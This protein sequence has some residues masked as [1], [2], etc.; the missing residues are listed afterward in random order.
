MNRNQHLLNWLTSEKLKDDK[1]LNRTKIN[2]AKDIV[3]LK[4]EQM[5]PEKKE[6]T[7]WQKIKILVLGN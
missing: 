2:Y 1:E 5:F 4:K 3:K 6:L 7:L